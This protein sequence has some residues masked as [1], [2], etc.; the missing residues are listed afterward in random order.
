MS[1]LLSLPKTA[2]WLLVTRTD[3]K[4]TLCMLSAELG[5]SIDLF[6]LD[7]VAVEAE[8]VM[9]KQLLSN[10]TLAMP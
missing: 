9:F 7:D 4:L 3:G 10:S 5:R 6:T 2:A 8:E 1:G